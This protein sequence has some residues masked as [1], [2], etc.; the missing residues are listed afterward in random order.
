MLVFK[1]NNQIGQTAKGSAISLRKSSM[2]KN[3]FLVACFLSVWSSDILI[4]TS[5]GVMIEYWLRHVG[6]PSLVQV[7]PVTIFI[8][9]SW[10]PGLLHV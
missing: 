7:I 4:A 10:A 6:I 2:N 1:Q 8:V 3:S 9:S 5:G